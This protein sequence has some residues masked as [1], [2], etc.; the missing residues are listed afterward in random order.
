MRMYVFSDPFGKSF[1]PFLTLAISTIESKD[2]GI[3]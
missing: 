1:P 3:P 2:I